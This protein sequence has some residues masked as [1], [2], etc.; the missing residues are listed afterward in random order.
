MGHCGDNVARDFKIHPR[1]NWTRWALRS[2]RARGQTRPIQG[3]FQAEEIVS[4]DVAVNGRTVR[5]ASI[6]IDEGP[7]RDTSLEALVQA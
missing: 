2:H 6:R 7:R 4:L 3:A 5:Y 1:R